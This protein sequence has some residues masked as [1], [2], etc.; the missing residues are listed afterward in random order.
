MD[1]RSDMARSY[2]ALVDATLHDGW[3]LE[4]ARTIARDATEELEDLGVD[5]GLA[6]LLGQLARIEMLI[7]EDFGVAIAVADRALAMAERLD[8]PALVADVLVTRGTALSSSGRALE[9]LGAIEAGRRLAQAE[10]LA[11][12]EARALLNMS[13]PLAERDPRAMLEASRR[14]LELARQIGDRAGV[15]M[16]TNNMAESA[17]L[18]GDWD[19]AI[20]ELRHE[21]EASSGE[22][23]QWIRNA[24]VPML[25]NR[26]EDTSAIVTPLLEYV[27][28]QAA[29]GEPA[30]QY[31]EDAIFGALDLPAGRYGDAARRLR[32]AAEADPFNAGLGY[33]EVALAAVLD[34]DVEAATSALAGMES[35]G[36]HGKL[37]KLAKR[38]TSAGIAALEGRLDEA[39]A[40]LQAVLADYRGMDL[41]FPVA[42]TGLMMA[43]LLDPSRPGVRE[44]A[45][46]AREIFE[47]L[48]AT[49]WLDRLDDALGVAA[50]DTGAAV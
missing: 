32:V 27:R 12:V 46:E 3:Q 15:S 11:Y 28:V 14:A 39:L 31:T 47:R 36:S 2:A 45:A 20:A 24:L 42:K 16:A 21:A 10:G 6:E 37:V 22:E 5:V 9:G 33:A 25:A 41:P 8:L 40:S 4:A 30:W 26:G 48:G 18:T 19:E 29:T 17:C 43:A 23:L 34:R 38:R 44:A 35:T 7:Q 13:G 1:R 49:A 50:R